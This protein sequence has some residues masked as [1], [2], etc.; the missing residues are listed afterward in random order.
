VKAYLWKCGKCGQ[1]S[2]SPIALPCYRT[3]LEH[4]GRKYDVVVH[5]LEVAQCWNCHA[6]V[7]DDNANGRLSDALR[8]A[9]GLLLPSEIRAQREALGLT[10]KALAAYLL[11]AEATLSR[12]E[13]GAQIQQRA[14]DAFLRVFFRS[15]EARC[16][17]G[18][19]GQ[20][21]REGGV[22]LTFTSAS[23]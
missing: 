5:N 7:L 13:T 2:V 10:Q 15:A 4:D 22:T 8:N 17:L 21:H 9:A 16:I 14:M 19:P 20:L 12:W 18:V 11:I 6:V 1:R 23:L 3:F